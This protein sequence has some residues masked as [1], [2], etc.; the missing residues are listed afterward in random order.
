M[1]EIHEEIRTKKEIK[2]IRVEKNTKGRN[3]GIGAA[4]GAAAL[5][6]AAFIVG[7][8]GIVAMGTGIGAPAGVGLIA[9]AAALGAAAGGITGAATGEQET[10]IEQIPYEVEDKV[11]ITTPK[12][13]IFEYSLVLGSG[14]ALI[15]V[16]GICLK[17]Q[18]SQ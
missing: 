3:A 6:G 1:T 10:I 2:E 5:G 15:M 8:I 14:I 17:K 11:V 9:G 13:T 7:G 18:K 12:Y 16:G 4:I